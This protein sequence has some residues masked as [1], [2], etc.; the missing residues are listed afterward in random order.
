MKKV[1][2][3][4]FVGMIVV[5]FFFKKNLDLRSAA[6]SE[7]LYFVSIIDQVFLDRCVNDVILTLCRIF[8]QQVLR[9]LCGKCSMQSQLSLYGL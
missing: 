1:R 7:E 3:L 5:V 2:A 8:C 6:G 4:I 9:M